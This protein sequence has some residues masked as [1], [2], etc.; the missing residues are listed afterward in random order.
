MAHAR[1]DGKRKGSR[2]LVAILTVLAGL[3][4]LV[5]APAVDAATNWIVH[6]TST[7]AGEGQAQT[8]P[9]APTG[10]TATCTTP[11]TLKTVKVAW[12]AVTHATTYSVYDSTTSSTGTYTLIASGVGTTSWTSGTL[13]SGSY[14]FKVAA[15]FGSNWTGT[16]SAASSQRTI[17]GICS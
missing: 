9:V 15:L 11:P 8:L 7:N 1:G 2:P 10:I 14:W 13:A 16:Q 5:G 17:S 12:N 6:V 4:T 3:V